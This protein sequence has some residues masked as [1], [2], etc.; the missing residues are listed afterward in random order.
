[1]PLICY[2]Q[3]KFD[4]ERL[5]MIARANLVFKKYQEQGFSLT[6]RQLYYVFV[7]NKYFPESWRYIRL[8]PDKWK[9]DPSGTSNAT[10][11]Y[12]ALG[13]LISDGR[14]SG[15]IDW[16]AIVDRTRA[17]HANQHWARPSQ[18]LEATMNTY[19]LDKWSDQPNYVEVWVEKEALEDVLDQACSPLDVRFFACRGYT[20]Q[21]AMWEASQ[22]LV[23]KVADGKRVHIIHLGDHDPSG[24]DMSRDI[25]QRLS[26]FVDHFEE[27]GEDEWND[28]TGK[29]NVHRIALNMNQVQEYNLPPD[30]AKISDPRAGGYIN[31]YGDE[32]WELDALEPQL[33]VDMISARVK[34]LRDDSLWETAL[35]NEARGKHTLECILKYFPDVVT[36]IR[37]RRKKDESP[38][39]CKDCGATQANPV[40]RCTDAGAPSIALG[41]GG[42]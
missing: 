29:V 12:N 9:R 2:E 38:V 21:S 6:L 10:P 13:K 27:Y 25:Y 31:K 30:P 17:S 19:A 18:I 3:K 39:I 28:G 4:S 5:D 20:S 26:L 33:L 8:G 40:C 35:K 11:N 22:R 1:M 37:E 32:S 41:P 23:R 42:K 15:L 34:S 14:M 36:F 7:G 24:V 16:N